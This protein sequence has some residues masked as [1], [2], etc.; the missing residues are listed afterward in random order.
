M[1]NKWT[2][3]AFALLKAVCSSAQDL[4]QEARKNYNR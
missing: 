4:Q 2:V 1:K 3:Q